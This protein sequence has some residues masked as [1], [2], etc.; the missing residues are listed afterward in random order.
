LIAFA[1][2]E[3]PS[4]LLPVFTTHLN[5]GIVDSAARVL[6]VG[7]IAEFLCPAR[8]G[9]SPPVLAGDLNCEPDADEI[10]II[11]GGAIVSR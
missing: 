11:T 4:G 9:R 2:I 8:I 1:N 3:T 6:Q 7:Q 5:S 10:R